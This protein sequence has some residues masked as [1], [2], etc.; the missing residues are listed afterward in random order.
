[1]GS[2]GGI[3]KA[4]GGG[5]NKYGLERFG[6]VLCIGSCHYE[7][8]D[9]GDGVDGVAGFFVHAGRRRAF[10]ALRRRGP[11][12]AGTCAAMVLAITVPIVLVMVSPWPRWA[13]SKFEISNL[14]SEI[15]H[16]HLSA[17]SLRP[18]PISEGE[19]ETQL[20][21][22]LSRGKSGDR[23]AVDEIDELVARGGGLAY[24]SR[25]QCARSC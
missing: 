18:G 23:N 1:M 6:Y 8:H 14:K 7:R 16:S 15:Q 3:R 9:C 21:T 25:W 20:R 4:E 11:N 17:A 2:E 12:A 5:R 10:F 19:G 22:R 13:F 24:S